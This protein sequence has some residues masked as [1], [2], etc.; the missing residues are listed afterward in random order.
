MNSE[1]PR[2]GIAPCEQRVEAN[3]QIVPEASLQRPPRVR[4]RR[5]PRLMEAGTCMQVGRRLAWSIAQ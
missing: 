1:I 2:V 3:L 5:A 4:D